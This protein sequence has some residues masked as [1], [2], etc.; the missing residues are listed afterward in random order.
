MTICIDG[1]V[2]GRSH[3]PFLI[4]EMSGNHNQ[5]LETALAIVD[6][7]AQAGAHAIK[8]QTYTADTLTINERGGSFKIND[9]ES[10]WAGQSLHDL[11]Q[12]AHTPWDWHKPIM[13]HAH[14]LGL[15]CF[16]S[17]FDETAVDF[18]EQLNVPAYKIASFEN[19]HLPL[20]HKAASTGKPLIISTGMASLGELD[21]AVRTA[22]D[23]GCTQLMLLKCTSSYPSSPENT[24]IRTIPHLRQLFN[25]EVGLSDHTMGV[26]VAVAS[27]A[28]GAT[29]IE[30]HFT[31]SR[32]DGGVDSAFSLEPNEFSALVLETERAWQSL[33]KVS[34]GPTDSERRS[35]VFRR[36]IYVVR[37][38]QPGELFT[39]ENIRIIRPGYGAPPNLYKKIIG[40]TAQY[41]Y[42]RGTPLSLDKLL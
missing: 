17:P 9:K 19:N 23:A 28:M 7:A 4:A 1:R 24:N 25:C 42:E 10:L 2:I 6:A 34:Y 27:V 41:P 3:S 15:I 16:S 14:E 11:Y 21:E 18:L 31:I 38:I 37:D 39:P 8:L 36:S 13:E 20:I 35:M 29:L 5:S 30:K 26:G 32:S 22:R 33:G 12:K 40:K